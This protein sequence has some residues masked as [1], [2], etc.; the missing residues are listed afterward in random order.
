MWPLS[1]VSLQWLD[2]GEGELRFE[3]VNWVG[4]RQKPIR[5]LRTNELD[6]SHDL[7]SEE[8]QLLASV[9]GD[10]LDGPEQSEADIFWLMVELVKPLAQWG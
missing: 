9:A 6:V 4:P 5:A 8:L 2:S 3:V 10:Q 7:N 1:C